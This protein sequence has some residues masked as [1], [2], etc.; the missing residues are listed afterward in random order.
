MMGQPEEI[1]KK[2]SCYDNKTQSIR[3][4]ELNPH[5]CRTSVLNV[6]NKD[7]LYTCSSSFLYMSERIKSINFHC[8]FSKMSSASTFQTLAI[9]K[10]SHHLTT[11]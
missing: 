11:S 4:N 7:K 3:F 1:I 6:K 8:F 5:Q 10:L 2:F 9:R